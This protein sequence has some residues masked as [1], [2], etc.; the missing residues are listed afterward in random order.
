M[1]ETDKPVNTLNKKI[2]TNGQGSTEYKLTS[3]SLIFTGLFIILSWVANNAW[4]WTIPEP[5]LWLFGILLG[6]NVAYAGG[7]TLFK[8]SIAK[9]LGSK[10]LK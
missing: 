6:S 7:R 3:L 1:D 8:N 5:V 10:L 2:T 4:G 9:A